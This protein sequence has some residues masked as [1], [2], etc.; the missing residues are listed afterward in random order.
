MPTLLGVFEHPGRRRRRGDAAQGP[1]LHRS[2]RSTRPAPFDEVDDAVDPKP[3]KV[4]IF[5][6]VGGLLGVVTGYA[7][8]IWMSLDWPIVI[9]GKPFASIPPYTVI[10]FE[11]TILF[12][13]IFTLLGL[14]AVGRLPAVEARPRLQR[15]LLRRGLRPRRRR[16]RARR[17]RGRRPAARQRRDG[18]E[19]CRGVARFARPSSAWSS[20]LPS[21]H[22]LLGAVV[23]RLVPADEV[24]EAP[25]RPSSGRASAERRGASCRPRAPCRSAR[26]APTT[27]DDA[28]RD[29]GARE[30]EPGH[31]RR[32]SRTARSST[33]PSA[34]RATARRARRRPG[35]MSALR[36]GPLHRRAA[37]RRSGRFAITKD[38]SDG[39]I[40]TMIRR[41]S[42]ACRPTS[43]FRRAI[44]GT[45]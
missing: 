33:T 36:Q 44:A 18:G 17:R 11:L 6:L 42:G 32:R 22:G 13:G 43:A 28:R 5:T 27:H 23:G 14:L 29:R 7:M 3:S 24:A 4:R 37:D 30:S 20:L 41:A 10:A 45:S 35:R 26:G 1:R 39:H 16:A 40:Y 19:P 31:A 12:G 38:L 21:S 34:L 9:G 2:S 15:A 8:T 25:C